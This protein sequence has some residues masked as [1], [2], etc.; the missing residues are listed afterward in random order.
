MICKYCDYE[1][2]NREKNPKSCPR[3]KRRFDCSIKGN[4]NGFNNVKCHRCGYEWNSNAKMRFVSCP[5][6]LAKTKTLKYGGK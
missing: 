3:C 4:K 6:C 2:R 1:W 5:N